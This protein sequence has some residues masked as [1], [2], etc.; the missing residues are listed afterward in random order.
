MQVTIE[1]PDDVDLE[2]KEVKAGI[3]ALLYEN[4]TLSEKQARKI[5]E[6]SRR[7]FQKLLADQG[8]AYMS[9]DPEDIKVELQHRD[10]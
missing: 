6:L 3:I 2:E 7:S 8:V 10:Q 4:G 9:N 5:L 1:L